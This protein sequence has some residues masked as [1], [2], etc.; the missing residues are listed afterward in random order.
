MQSATAT[1]KNDHP[2]P[3]TQARRLLLGV[4]VTTCLLVLAVGSHLLG[5]HLDEQAAAEKWMRALT[6]SAPALWPAGSPLRHPETVHAGV[7]LRFAVGVEIL[8]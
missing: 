2:A 8:P 1:L 3:C 4:A 7:D 5:H 6:L